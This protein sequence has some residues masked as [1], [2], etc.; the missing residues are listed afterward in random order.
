MGKQRAERAGGLGAWGGQAQ[1]HLSLFPQPGCG[2]HL[3]N[4][5]ESPSRRVGSGS[6]PNA[7]PLGLVDASAF[8]RAV[9]P[10]RF[11]QDVLVLFTDGI[12]DQENAANLG[13]TAGLMIAR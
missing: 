13:V 12:V 3:L 9:V 7:P 1:S 8:G 2:A 6:G 10:W 11:T 4:L 5:N